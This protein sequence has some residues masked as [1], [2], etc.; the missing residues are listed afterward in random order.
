MQTPLTHATNR[1]DWT[2]AELHDDWSGKQRF[3]E[4]GGVPGTAINIQ[5][6]SKRRGP[7]VIRMRDTKIAIRYQ[8]ACQ[9]V[10]S[11]N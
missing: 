4:L 10:V 3:M 1:V 2:I 5:K 9:I 11:Q 7:V 8:D 6:A